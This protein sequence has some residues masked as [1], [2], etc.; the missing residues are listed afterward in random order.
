M[1]CGGIIKEEMQNLQS[2]TYYITSLHLFS[3]SGWLAL[4][5]WKL[6]SEHFLNNILCA[7]PFPIIS[8]IIVDVYDTGFYENHYAAAQIATCKQRQEKRERE[9]ERGSDNNAYNTDSFSSLPYR[10]GKKFS[11]F[12]F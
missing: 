12:S 9:R 11:R 4:A 2:T 7:V 5:D 1:A 6:E 3:L 10:K 8:I